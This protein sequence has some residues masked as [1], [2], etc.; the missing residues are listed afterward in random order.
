MD[1]LW[2]VSQKCQIALIFNLREKICIKLPPT[3]TILVSVGLFCFY[4]LVWFW[5]KVNH[6]WKGKKIKG[7]KWKRTGYLK[8][9]ERNGADS[10]AYNLPGVF[11]LCRAGLG[12]VNGNYL[13]LKRGRKD[14]ETGC[15][16]K[17]QVVSRILEVQ[18]KGEKGCKELLIKQLDVQ[19]SWDSL[20]KPGSYVQVGPTQPPAQG[21]WE[22]SCRTQLFWIPERP[23]FPASSHPFQVELHKTTSL[24]H[25]ITQ[26]KKTLFFHFQIF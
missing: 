23:S 20:L 8:K 3:E 4:F 12:W 16:R 13:I 9:P 11:C 21:Y 6:T 7:Q 18:K 2:K 10:P 26:Y 5:Y 14:D 25:S 17:A 1:L 19:L 15:K 24:V 22:S